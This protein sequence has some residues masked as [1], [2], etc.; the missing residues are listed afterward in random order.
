MLTIYVGIDWKTGWPVDAGTPIGLLVMLPEIQRSRRKNQMPVFYVH[1][2]WET[3]W[4]V[5]TLLQL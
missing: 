2:D 3:G 5:D 1:V 4:P